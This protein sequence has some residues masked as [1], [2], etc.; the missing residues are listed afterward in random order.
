M[1]VQY[2]NRQ[3]TAAVQIVFVPDRIKNRWH[4]SSRD[5]IL[6]YTNIYLQVAVKNKIEKYSIYIAATTN[7]VWW[8]LKTLEKKQVCTVVDPLVQKVH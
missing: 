5:P 7:I 1:L 3:T 6:S 4:Q 2:G 8:K